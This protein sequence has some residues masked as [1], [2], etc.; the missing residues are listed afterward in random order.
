MWAR[1]QEL[2][3]WPW[4]P[5]LFGP[6]L[7]ADWRVVVNSKSLDF[8]SGEPRHMTNSEKLVLSQ[9]DEGRSAFRDWCSNRVS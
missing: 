1:H 9:H 8:H 2:W 5:G 6:G 4:S 3:P 7:R